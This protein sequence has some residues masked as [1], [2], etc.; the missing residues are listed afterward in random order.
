MNTRI[1]TIWR[2]LSPFAVGFDRTF[3]TLSI[4][5]N[6]KTQN[7]NYPPYNIRKLPEEKYSIE[8]AVAGF[9][10]KDIDIEVSEQNLTIDGRKS[11][12]M[13]ENL[14]HQGLASRNFNRKFVLSEDMVVQNA[15]LSNGILYIGIQ[16]VIPEHKKPKKIPLTSKESLLE[17]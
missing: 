5:A 2:D 15:A 6:S 10:E 16:R 9:D 3:D 17:S 8:L 4:L 12:E 14:I 7:T 1:E 11:D 13:N